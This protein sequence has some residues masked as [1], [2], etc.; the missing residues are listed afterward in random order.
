MA[1]A[2]VAS[3]PRCV[4]PVVVA[5]G[6]WSGARS[7]FWIGLREGE[8]EPDEE[9]AG[10]EEVGGVARWEVVAGRRGGRWLWAARLEVVA[11]RRAGRWLWAAR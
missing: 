2:V 7:R 6:S 9:M 3:P 5:S 10:Q 8:V 1:G 4:S 11:G